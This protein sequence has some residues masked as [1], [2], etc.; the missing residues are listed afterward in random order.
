MNP[1]HRGEL[2]GRAPRTV[3][4]TPA[5]AARLVALV[6]M[7][8]LLEVLGFTVNSQTRRCACRL[9]EGANPTSFAWT[10][11]GL[12]KCH[13][14]GAGGNKV[15]LIMAARHCTF[16]AAVKFLAEL[17]GL[18]IPELRASRFALSRLR[19]QRDAEERA[20]Q[21]L[22]D[23]EHSLTIALAQQ[24]DSLRAL[25]RRA[26]VRL[27]QGRRLEACWAA[28]QYTA[29]MLPR[30]D[31]GYC[32]AAF[33][34]PVERAKFALHPEVRAAM[35]DAVLERGYVRAGNG[36]RFEVPHQ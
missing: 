35:I 23:I 5:T 25:R 10:A 21:V 27:Q 14:C 22:A 16:P 12:W 17:V 1:R 24:L 11:D 20:A 18:Q 4:A 13:S 9:H 3:R 6:P 31:A 36:Y 34:A 2:G 26:D 33:A 15:A 8:R 28:I 7:N 32:I 30:I 19:H 29:Q